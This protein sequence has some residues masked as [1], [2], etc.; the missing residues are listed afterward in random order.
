MATRTFLHVGTPKS[1]TTYLQA[2]LWRN[3]AGLRRDGLLLPGSFQAHYAAAKGVTRAPGLGRET[4]HDVNAAW[5]RLVEQVNAWSGDALISHELLAPAS[6]EQAESARARLVGDVH[7]VLTARA[8]HKQLP[9]SWQEQVRSGVSTPYDTFVERVK[10]NTGKGTWFWSVQ[11]LA[12]IANRWASGLPADRVHIVTVPADLSD[13]TLLWQRYAAL[14][15]RNPAAYDIETP[16]RNASLGVVESELLRRVHAA[17]DDRFT[18]RR[19][20]RWTRKLLATE[21]LGQRPGAPIRTPPDVRSWLVARSEAML[22]SVAGAGYHVV[23]DLDEL[24]WQPASDNARLLSSVTDDEIAEAG[25]WTIAQLQKT[26]M[27]RQLAEPSPPVTPDDGVAGILELLEQLRAADTSG[28]PRRRSTATSP[29][30]VVR[31]ARSVPLRRQ[32]RRSV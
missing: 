32:G 2:V 8:L 20:H 11:D 25:A 22:E 17:K 23:G 29:L 30:G 5:P 9:A 1:G 27:R 31:R 7:L 19:R 10:D 28:S 13:P 15:G 26:L 12:G 21:I 14:V 16:R 6:R 4:R 18:D 24:T 3:A